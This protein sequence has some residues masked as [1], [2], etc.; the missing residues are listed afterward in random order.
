[1][2]GAGLLNTKPESYYSSGLVLHA[3]KM[4]ITCW[5][6]WKSQVVHQ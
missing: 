1:M 2:G 4:V 6:F 3:S 5:Q